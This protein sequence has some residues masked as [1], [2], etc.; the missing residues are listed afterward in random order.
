MGYVRFDWPMP[1]DDWLGKTV[2]LQDQEGNLHESTV[3]LLPFIDKEKQ[4]PR[5]TWDGGGQ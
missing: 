5:A 4:L 1:D 2:L 3:D